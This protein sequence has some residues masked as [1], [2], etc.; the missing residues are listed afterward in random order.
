MSREGAPRSN[1]VDLR[2]WREERDRRLRAAAAEAEGAVRPPD[3]IDGRYRLLALVA[4]L[5]FIAFGGFLGLLFLMLHRE[6]GVVA[7]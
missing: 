6:D 2:R 7:W 5:G 1:V 4:G 3:R